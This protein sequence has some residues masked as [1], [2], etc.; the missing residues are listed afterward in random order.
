LQAGGLVVPML[1][2]ISEMRYLWYVPHR[3][4]GERMTKL[5]G[6]VAST[7]IDQAMD[8]TLRELFG[9]R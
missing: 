7:P 1:R 6:K 4:A 5:V 9:E 2:E 8:D 3:L